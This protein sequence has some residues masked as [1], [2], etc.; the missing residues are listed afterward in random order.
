MGRRAAQAGIATVELVVSAYTEAACQY[1]DE[2]GVCQTYYTQISVDASTGPIEVEV[3]AAPEDDGCAIGGSAHASPGTFG[4][5]LL[6]IMLL[7]ILAR[8]NSRSAVR[9]YSGR[10]DHMAHARDGHRAAG[11]VAKFLF[12][13]SARGLSAWIG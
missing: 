11:V 2:F 4:L 3:V 7:C 1:E 10:I 9:R 5:L 13:W 12:M 8:R 6:L